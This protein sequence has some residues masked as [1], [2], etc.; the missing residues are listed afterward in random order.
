MEFFWLPQRAEQWQQ[1]AADKCDPTAT[2]A[3]LKLLHIYENEHLKEFSSKQKKNNKEQKKQ[4]KKRTH[5]THTN[6]EHTTHTHLPRTHHTHTPHTPTHSHTDTP[7]TMG[8][9]SRLWLTLLCCQSRNPCTTPKRIDLN[10]WMKMLRTR[11]R[12]APMALKSWSVVGTH[13]VRC[14]ATF[15]PNETF[16]FLCVA[17][18]GLQWSNMPTTL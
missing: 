14:N 17:T 6:K 1:A 8:S 18:Q 3:F 13:Q 15:V 11:R 4:N 16:Q 9:V 10:E 5:I 2:S 12:S 7:H